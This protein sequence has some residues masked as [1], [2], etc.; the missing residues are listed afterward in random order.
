MA[1][2]IVMLSACAQSAAALPWPHSEAGFANLAAAREDAHLLLKALPVPP[3]A[4]P[5]VKA[6]RRA[7][8]PP[9]RRRPRAA[10]T[11]HTW[12]W[13]T[14]PG[15]PEAAI[16]WMIANPPA[17][18][19][20]LGAGHRSRFRF[21]EEAKLEIHLAWNPQRP[22]TPGARR[23]SRTGPRG[24]LDPPRRRSGAAWFLPRPPEEQIPDSVR[25]LRPTNTS[26]PRPR[27]S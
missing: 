25:V 2:A 4:T 18:A 3:G 1:V 13:W 12:S 14:V 5:S 20:S 15:E 9:E 26:R 17:G 7:A 6:R 21:G 24:L 10:T 23:G 22:H 27:G 8:N 19:A 16:E 11:A